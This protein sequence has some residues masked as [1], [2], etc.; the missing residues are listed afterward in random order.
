MLE[1]MIGTY[2]VTNPEALAADR[3]FFGV[4]TSPRL[5]HVHERCG[6]RWCVLTG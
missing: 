2:A 3:R 5:A 1:T 4:E 6:I